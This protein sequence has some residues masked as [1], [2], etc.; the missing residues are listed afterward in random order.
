MLLRFVSKSILPK[1]LNI[2]GLLAGRAT[3]AGNGVRGE[4][5]RRWVVM[6]PEAVQRGEGK[7]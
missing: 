5:G 6:G 4:G 1:D 3:A 7:N 2:G